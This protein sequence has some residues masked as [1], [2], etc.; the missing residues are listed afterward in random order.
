QRVDEM[1]PGNRATRL[2]DERQQHL[3]LVA[4]RD[5]NDIR[6]APHFEWAENPVLEPHFD[7]SASFS[8]ALRTGFQK[9][10]A[11]AELADRDETDAAAKPRRPP[12]RRRKRAP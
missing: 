8:R 12:G 4:P 7:C 1:F 6:S 5:R 10:R 9:G 3:A 11:S 2:E